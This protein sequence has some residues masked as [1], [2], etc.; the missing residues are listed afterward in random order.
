MASTAPLSSS[1]AAAAAAAADDAAA[2]AAAPG[3][4]SS[5]AAAADAAGASPSSSSPAAAPDDKPASSYAGPPKIVVFGGRGFVGSAVCRE[6][7][8]T[9]LHVVAVSPAGTPPLG[10]PEWSKNV[11]WARGD[12]LEPRSY[13]QHLAGALG[14]VSCV[15]AFGSR[16]AMRRVNGDANVAAI[17][18]AAQAGV[19]RFCYVSAQMPPLP[20]AVENA[21]LAGYADGKRLAEGALF[22]DYP[23]TG[24]ALRPWVVYGDRAVSPHVTLPLGLLFGTFGAL[25]RRLLP[26]GSAR[27][28]A[29]TPVLGAAAL[30][31]NAV[32]A[33][34][35][36]AVAAATDDSV[37]GG[38]ID[39]WDINAQY[40]G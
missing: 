24:V 26:G 9:G 32:E 11:E 40:G 30:P 21:L 20:G 18:A 3:A 35:R 33:V 38:I 8:R 6:A 37:P 15:G 5:S 27:S 2:A 28:L 7:L 36:A 4:P 13:A 23:R 14:A 25:Q 17:A 29:Q 19:P 31:P 22:R 16:A 34:A 12:A 1:S 10:T 39:C